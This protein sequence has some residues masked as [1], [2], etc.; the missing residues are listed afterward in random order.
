MAVIRDNVKIFHF[1]KI[2]LALVL[3]S[4]VFKFF[5]TDD[6]SQYFHYKTYVE[7][8]E[9]QIDRVLQCNQ[10]ISIKQKFLAKGNL[11]NKIDIYLGDIEENATGTL[12]LQ[13]Q[14][15][16]D[17]ILF[18]K[19]IFLSDYTANSWNTIESN[20][21]E[22]IRGEIYQLIIGSKDSLVPIGASNEKLQNK[23]FLECITDSGFNGTAG[24]GFQFTYIYSTFGDILFLLMNVLLLILVV[25]TIIFMLIKVDIAYLLTDVY[26]KIDIL[27]AVYF[28]TL[29]LS[30]FNP[31]D[32]QKLQVTDFKREIGMSAVSNI[33]VASRIGNF[34]QCLG[35]FILFYTLFFAVFKYF[36]ISAQNIENKE[37][38]KFSDN[39]IILANMMLIFRIIT[40]FSD[41]DQKIFYYS[42]YLI[43]FVVI[44]CVLFNA[45]HLEKV[46]SAEHYT[47]IH[48]SIFFA[49]Y[50]VASLIK[51]EWLG[52]KLLLGLNVAV[53]TIVILLLKIWGQ[54]IKDRM[55]TISLP[56]ITIISSFIPFLTALYIEILNIF[57]QHK[58][59]IG[60]PGRFYYIFLGVILCVITFL[61]Y[62]RRYFEKQF[63][64]KKL[65]Y[66]L[67]IF[68]ISCMSVQIPLQM[69]Y[70]AHIY[71][72]ANY[73][74]LI[75]DFLN[76]G[77][78]PIVEHYGGHMLTGVWEGL[79]YAILNNDFQGAIFSPYMGLICPV[80]SVLFYYCIKFSWNEDIAFWT[81]L[82]FPFYS[83]WSY[84]GLGM[85]VCVAAIT[86]VRK[87]TYVRALVLWGTV[88]W[89]AFYRLDLGFAFG[90]ACIIFL[91]IYNCEKKNLQIVKQLLLSFFYIT[92][93]FLLLWFALC[94]GK[95][96]NPIDR[97]MEFLQISQSNEIWGGAN[98]GNTEIMLF[99]WSYVIVPII[100]LI[101][102]CI[103]V[104]QKKFRHVDEKRW[105]ILVFFG[106]SYFV[107]FQR[108]LV[109]HSVAE[110]DTR[111]VLWSAYV[112]LALFISYIYKKG[113][114]L[115]P[116]MTIL[117]LCNTLFIQNGIF[118]EISIIDRASTITGGFIETWRLGRFAKED[119]IPLE[120]N[121]DTSS[122]LTD[123][124][125]GANYITEN[126]KLLTGWEVIKKQKR[127]VK[128]VIYNNELNSRICPYRMI[129]DNLLD[130]DETYLDF[131][132]RSFIYSAIERYN[133]VYIAQ[134]PMLLSSDFTQEQF[135]KEIESNNVPVAIM[136][137]Y[138]SELSVT[139]DAVANVYR[140]YKVAEYIYT[141]Y[142]PLCSYGEFSVWCLPN[143]YVEMKQKIYNLFENVTDKFMDIDSLEKSQCE[144]VKDIESGYIIIESTGQDTSINGLQKIVSLQNKYDVDMK[145]TIEYETS[146]GGTMQLYYTTD[147]EE[148]YSE[149][150]SIAKP[151]IHS[152]KV[153]FVIPVTE[154]SQ[155]RLDVSE[156][157]KVKI[158]EVKIGPAVDEIDWGYDGPVAVDGGSGKTLYEYIGELHNYN[159]G[160]LPVIWAEHDE[161][162]A[163]ENTR[164]ASFAKEG[165]Y[166]ILR[167]PISKANKDKGN[168]LYF[169]ANFAGLDWDN[170]WKSDDETVE[171][172]IKL[173][174]YENGEFKERFNYN[175]VLREGQHDYLMRIS[176]DYYWYIED[177]NALKVSCEIPLQD[178]EAGILEGD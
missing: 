1:A 81:T 171:A 117:L 125:I 96:I 126:E 172:S 91:I 88:V 20:C 93:F 110:L 46:I 162:K 44:A 24:V 94:I 59:F 107:N 132:N 134:S 47:N 103:I 18:D 63:Q 120:N 108:G 145:V 140:H 159:L 85:L 16:D 141:H 79:L 158:G 138:D 149:D 147:P 130:Q 75:S 66:P 148:E 131:M 39:L 136:P 176:S 32:E 54:R 56:R 114:L 74:I 3:L 10:T 84:F 8:N 58:I 156:G 113:K 82:V 139:L 61:L 45:M 123:I 57:N 14:D 116:I 42:S 167:K 13:I 154:Y 166:F 73:S 124:N 97:L 60:A 164:L 41:Y 15:Q 27:Y 71:E 89:C 153:D 11:L 90:A 51:T 174:H 72:S 143:R 121:Q 76:F 31:L 28:A 135:I 12:N 177:I 2:V 129:M 170:K 173:G 19:T 150:K 98:I 37:I 77:K 25:A 111:V 104:F 175:I 67:G 17:N 22:L 106:V 95:G 168:Y 161:K 35:L 115:I 43:M 152:G 128:R 142:Q 50:I 40:Y 36:R 151:I 169:T 53:S 155:L 29:V 30:R 7:K 4:I 100:T 165:E 6:F 80:L 109:R 64:W 78:I 55:P 92:I 127:V 87:T 178:I 83:S 70:E 137:M 160:Q 119:A 86:Y 62:K 146:K 101:S 68:G 48:L 49:S 118:K 26:N 105:I 5:L 144:I 23:V 21:K 163:V 112:F 102:L 33:E 69:I 52:G 9:E 65:V 38:Y 99:P 133:P 122:T 157:C 34:L